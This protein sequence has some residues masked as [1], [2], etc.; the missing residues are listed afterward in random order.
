MVHGMAA[1]RSVCVCGLRVV[2]GSQPGLSVDWLVGE[3]RIR[4]GRLSMD[5]VVVPIVATVAGS[6]RPARLNGVVGAE[7]T[8]IVTVRTESAVLEWSMLRRLDG[9]ALRAL[10]VPD[11][12]AGSS[13]G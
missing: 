3:W 2:S 6:R 9:L 13:P 12:A 11:T 7:D 10:G 5:K 1:R 8:I 4:A